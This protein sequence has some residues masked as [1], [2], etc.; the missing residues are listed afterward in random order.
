MLTG[1]GGNIGIYIGETHVFMI[2]DQ[3][4]RLSEK[5]KNT[6]S[7]LTEK[8]IAFLFNT[9]MHGDPLTRKNFKAMF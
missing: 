5:L 4:D 7:C 6:I 2:D 8:P 1:Q 9:H 3:L